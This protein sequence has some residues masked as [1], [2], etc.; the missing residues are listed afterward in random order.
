M[1]ATPWS[2][3]DARETLVRGLSGATVFVT[4]AGGMLGRAF[5]WVLQTVVPTARI[6]LRTRAD[7]DVTSR[8]AVMAAGEVSPDIVIHCAA[9]VD[10]DACER[11]PQ[12]ARHVIVEGGRWVA[13]MAASRGAR[14]IFPQSFLIYGETS[15]DITEETIP[16]P[17]SEYGRLKWEAESM[18]RAIVP[19]ALVVRMGGFFGGEEVDKNFVGKF[20]RRLTEVAASGG[21][22]L[23][24][25][26][27]R[28]QPTYTRDL[29]FNTLLLAASGGSGA[30]QMAS[31]GSATF[32]DVAVECV[33]ALGLQRSV[34]IGAVGADVAARRDVARRPMRAVM[35]NARLGREQCDL[36]RPWREALGEY[37]RSPYFDG[38]RSSA[39]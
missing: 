19:S 18:M 25:G 13:E 6:E 34:S 26:G 28:W 24:V 5:A 8:D 23:E 27:R 11:E 10:A 17:M 30:F 21:G 14:L 12:R 1:C 33:E 37:L 22:S 32:F 4:G 3:E 16:D 35:R 2:H 39:G 20:V 15:G 7:L 36:Q 9:L 38:S 31:L 29:A